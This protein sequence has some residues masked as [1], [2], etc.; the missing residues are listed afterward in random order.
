MSAYRRRLYIEAYFQQWDED[1]Y[2]NT[3][4]F[5][6]NNYRQALGILEHDAHALREVMVFLEISEEQMVEWEK[7]ELTFFAT[8]GE[9]EPY[10]I[11]KVAYVELLQEYRD[12]DTA[13]QRANTRFRN[14]STTEAMDYSQNT[15][16]TKRQEWDRR[17][18]SKR[19]EHV[20]LEICELEVAL[21]I[22]PGQRW[23]PATQ[24]YQD[25]IKYIHEHKYRRAL[26]KLQKL[27]VQRL[28]ELHKLNLAQTG[29]YPCITL[30][31][32]VLITPEAISLGLISPSLYKHGAR[33]SGRLLPRTISPPPLSLLRGTRLTGARS[34]TMGSWRSLYSCKTL[35]TTSVGSR[36]FD[37]KSVKL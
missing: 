30:L 12:L 3:G 1:K 18:A 5:I 7:E 14:I 9:G 23:T 36:G 15:S 34:R 26:D 27:V 17:H 33:R 11:R 37:Q 35:A 13:R 31:I 21:D 10:D 25:T 20:S 29:K 2:L 6:L 19:L 8:L 22:L 24:D 28:F 16:T 32:T 4:T